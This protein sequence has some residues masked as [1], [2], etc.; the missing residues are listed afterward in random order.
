MDKEVLHCISYGMY[1]VSS[2][3]QD[4]LNGQ[5][6]NTVFQIT[7]KPAIVA[8]SINKQ[9]LTYDLISK[10]RCF[11]VS[12]LEEE[13]PMAFIGK[14]G[15]KSGRSIDKFKDT[16]FKLLDSGCPVALDYALCYLE[17]KVVNQL[18]CGTHTVFAGEVVGSQILKEAR[19]LTYDYYHNVKRGLTHKNAPTYI[20]EEK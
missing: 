5:I 15:F 19:P 7:N 18:E 14:F 4:S 20:K 2:F 17:A 10:S 11:S 6:A 13:T 9:N 1:V 3:S 12:I 8:V 16:K